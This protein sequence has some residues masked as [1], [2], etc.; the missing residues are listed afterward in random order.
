M[1]GLAQ[2]YD[3]TST[4]TLVKFPTL[5]PIGLLRLVKDVLL[6]VTESFISS[7]G[8]LSANSD[9]GVESSSKIL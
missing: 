6:D 7:S 2:N 9:E 5:D 1:D 4:Y 8:E 3:K